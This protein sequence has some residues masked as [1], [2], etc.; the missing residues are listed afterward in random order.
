M[1]RDSR[2]YRIS[3]TWPTLGVSIAGQT[4]DHRLYHFVLAYSAWE[5][6][7]PVLGG[8]SFTALAVGLQ[9]ALWSL[10]GVPVEHRSDS[11]SAAFRNL[12]D[13]ARVDQ[14]RRYE[15]LC[16]H[17]EMT[18][19]RNNTGVAHENGAIESQHGHLKRGVAQALL[20]RGSADFDS[21][22]AYRAW[23]AN[24]I[25]RRNAR[26][27]KMVQLE[28]A[29]LRPLPPGRTTDYDEA[30]VF[31]TSSSGFVLRKVFYTVPSRLIGFR[32]RVRLY[33]ERL[34]CFVGQSL[35]LTLC[36]G[37]G[38]AEGRHGHVVDYRH[39][40][41]S[42][43]R[44]PMALLNLVY[45]DALFPRPA[46]RLAW[47]KLLASRRSANAPASRWWRFWRWRMIAAAKPNSPP[48]SPSRWQVQEAAG[49]GVIDVP[50][51]QAR[52]APVPATMPDIVV[53]LPPVASYDVLL[54]HGS[55]GM[56][57]STS[58]TIKVD[59]ARLPLLLRELRLPTIAA[60][61]QT[62][63]ER[64]DREGW[65]AARLLAT[66]T[67]LEL[68][69]RDPATHPATSDR[70][71]PAT[72]QNSRQLRLCRRADA[73]PCPRRRA[74]H[75]RRMDRPWRHDPVVRPER[76]GK[77]ASQRRLRPCPD[78]E[79]LPRVVHPNHRSRA[80]SAAGASG[81]VAGERDR[82]AR[83]IPSPHPRGPLLCA[84]GSG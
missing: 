81:F 19:T 59:T 67:E 36:R 54:S 24:L 51:L 40:I 44:K 55:R 1:C 50:A 70:G 80:A 69:E 42:L 32:M 73:Q 5:H 47:E 37:R 82:E 14:T 56:N 84:Q 30:T 13:D 38:Q 53:S 43:R 33:D 68:A 23:I 39:V 26:R 2:R 79:R 8:E 71:P 72:R 7:E 16:A 60:M 78:R 34:E 63:T 20:L 9:N 62:F 48:R 28:C 21:L 31:V 17:Y 27:G 66:L 45:R 49:G 11:L 41:H 25:G 58:D 75:R 52:F 22:D 18:P 57:D 64:A 76:L 77:V 74:R 4:L 15:A 83:Q 3:P 35:A 10:G 6:A 65:P 61:W 29:A 46:Y 12:D